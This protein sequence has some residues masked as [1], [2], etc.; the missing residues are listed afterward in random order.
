MVRIPFKYVVISVDWGRCGDPDSWWIDEYDTYEE[1]VKQ[2]K[3]CLK[4]DIDIKGFY[5]AQKL[6]YE[7]VK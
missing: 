2:I 6:D 5:K 7:K 4:K 3:I 1:A